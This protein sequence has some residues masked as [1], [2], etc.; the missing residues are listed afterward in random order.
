[1]KQLDTDTVLAIIE[2][3]EQEIKWLDCRI[4]SLPL[5]GLK[6]KLQLCIEEPVNAGCDS[7]KEQ[8]KACYC[9]AG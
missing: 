3:I 6:K 4:Q 8:N 2:M 5:N 7:C 9:M 1:M